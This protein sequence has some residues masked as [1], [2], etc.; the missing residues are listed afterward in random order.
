M[1][2]KKQ[3][4][5]RSFFPKES[6][7]AQGA[8]AGGG[9]MGGVPLGRQNTYG[10]PVKTGP[11]YVN[12]PSTPQAQVRKVGYTVP[13]PLTGAFGYEGP[14]TNL[15]KRFT[16]QTPTYT[17]QTFTPGTAGKGGKR[18]TRK[19]KANAKTRKSKSKS[20]GRK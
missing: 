18:K 16:A 4:N 5:I 15:Y 10:G 1:S 3:T 14:N 6:A 19:A 8:A 11:M 17:P 2:D 13:T 20:K 12:P 9:G 7:T